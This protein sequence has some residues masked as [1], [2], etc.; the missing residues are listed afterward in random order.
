ML[1][2][3]YYRDRGFLLIKILFIGLCQDHSANDRDQAKRSQ[4][5]NNA[6]NAFLLAIIKW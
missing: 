3:F 1:W 5:Q 2:N 4:D 6:T